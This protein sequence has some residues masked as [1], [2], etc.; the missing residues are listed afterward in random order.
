MVVTAALVAV[1]ASLRTPSEQEDRLLIVKPRGL[2]SGLRVVRA[3]CR[4]W[5]ALVPSGYKRYK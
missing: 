2:K 4:S 5:R 3:A 1:R